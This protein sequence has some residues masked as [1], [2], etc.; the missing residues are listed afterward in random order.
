MPP[1]SG[2]AASDFS[3]DV[4]VSHASEDKAAFVDDLVK[5][6]SERGLR[7]WYDAFE[8]ALGD[9]FRRKMEQGL[10]GSRFGVVVL[11][12]AF[13]Q[14]S[15]YWTQ[16][17]VSA[18][19]N[20]EAVEGEKRILPVL[21]GVDWPTLTRTFPFL[22][23]R[24]A[25]DVS[26]G[27]DV[28][29]NQIQTAVRGVTAPPSRRA[30]PLYNVP[31]PSQS[32]V[33]RRRELDALKRAFDGG[34]VRVS[35]AV[36]GLPGVGK[37]E[38]ALKLAHE[39]A[40][41]GEFPGGIF[42]LPAENP[43]LTTIWSGDA[44][45]GA[46][47]MA[48]ETARDR[49][50]NTVNHLARRDARVLIILDNVERWDN[51]SQ[52]RPLPSG[53]NVTLLVT[54]RR[55]HLGGN[56]FRAF[57]LEILGKAEASLLVTGIAGG[58]V[59]ARDG[60][61]ELLTEL[62]GHALAVELAGV[63]LREYPDATPASYLAMLRAGRDPDA[64]VA[65]QARYE[66]GVNQA[67]ELL[68]AR[69]DPATQALWLRASLFAPE[70]VSA[71]LADACG[72]DADARRALHRY[73]LVDVDQDG[74]FRMHRLTRAFGGRCGE[75][76]TRKEARLAFLNG[77][78]A[79]AR[80]VDVMDGFRT[81][82][83]DRAHF[84]EALSVAAGDPLV[85]ARR[86][87]VLDGKAAALYS[88]GEIEAARQLREEVLASELKEYGEDHSSVAAS[89]SNLALVLLSLGE[90]NRARELLE[91]AIQS[92]VRNLGEDHPWVAIT[93]SNLATVL[94]DANE[95]AR[96]RE[97]AEL[98]LAS[99]LKNLGEDDEQVAV[100]RSNLSS[101]FQRL[102]DLVRARELLE[103]ALA[104]GLKNLGEDHPSVAVRRYKLSLLYEAEGD[105]TRALELLEEVLR[106]ETRSLGVEHPSLALTRAK[107]AN[108]LYKTGA[109]ERARL[110]AQEARRVVSSQPP[111]SRNR[112]EVEH[113]TAGIL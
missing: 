93:R 48:G 89:R 33:G 112:N 87:D 67:F 7:V 53:P 19:F 99:N 31:L 43:D 41:A 64:K 60:F 62:D 2:P 10:L 57:P 22:A 26:A 90:A 45:A 17:E 37:T 40:A 79:R 46:L 32:F 96:A 56:R 54:T 109:I 97:V 18:L 42:W 24:R 94:L 20:F 50:N 3:Y 71:P 107:V 88:L 76:V 100:D 106:S 49:A 75:E 77:V 52:P 21:Y 111:G 110:E 1:T 39:L 44:V 103:L 8:I 80:S 15:K 23:T 12:P 84:D 4:F 86:R 82:T 34:D 16:A 66:H 83:P 70:P 108:L 68:W 104:S 11:S 47:G 95:P 55:S 65:D 14:A 28:V 69:L 92:Y 63:Y 74:S 51:Q 5:A 30:S 61:E 101:I 27:V 35:A 73:H 113:L 91:Q 72:L 78:A 81:Y 105:R 85:L 102:G 38:L 59:A 9:D 29:A 13:M 58:E 98:A 6:L 36:E 25:A